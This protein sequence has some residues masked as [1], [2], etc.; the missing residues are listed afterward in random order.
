MP[1]VGVKIMNVACSADARASTRSDGLDTQGA[2]STLRAQGMDARLV[3][4][5]RGGHHGA[6][7]ELLRRHGPMM[8]RVAIR[9]VGNRSE[10]ED[11]VQDALVQVFRSIGGFRGH[12][13]FTTWLHR[14][15]VNAAL[16][17]VRRSSRR[18]EVSVEPWDCRLGMNEPQHHR[19]RTHELVEAR[20]EVRRAWAALTR[21]PPHYRSVIVLRDI[22][23][24]STREA[25]VRIGIGESATKVRLHRARCALRRSLEGPLHPYVPED[26]SNGLQSM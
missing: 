19:L 14:I 1:L 4:Q 10:A 24:L 9:V 21:L 22:E 15:V 25:A 13:A 3:A 26:A 8:S 11:V 20:I 16:M 7:S 17:R 5:L 18:L 2:G 12:S 6:Y 23:G